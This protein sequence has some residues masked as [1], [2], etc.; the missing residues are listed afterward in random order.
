M[1]PQ[2]LCS[3]CVSPVLLEASILIHPVYQANVFKDLQERYVYHGA[4][5]KYLCWHFLDWPDF[6]LADYL[7]L[8][9]M[10]FKMPWD[11]DSS[12]WLFTQT[13]MQKDSDCRFQEWRNASKED[14]LQG[15]FC[16][17]IGTLCGVRR[18]C[19]NIMKMVS[20]SVVWKE[21]LECVLQ[22]LFGKA[23][24]SSWK[25]NPQPSISSCSIAE[26]PSLA[27]KLSTVVAPGPG[28]MKIGTIK[29]CKQKY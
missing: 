16:C 17:C 11:M 20:S 14:I 2:S 1:G 28:M 12:F 18:C 26:T 21:A 6:H 3:R 25:Q 19:K 7:F 9:W 5:S 13:K 24:D 10:P 22:I 15:S 4:F 27:V 29:K 8:Y 23:S